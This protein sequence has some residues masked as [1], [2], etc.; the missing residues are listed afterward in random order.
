MIV[1]T[2][3][4]AAGVMGMS[5]CHDRAVAAD[6][7]FRKLAAGVLT[8]IPP[9]TSADDTEQHGDL[10]EITRGRADS[11]WK[12]NEAPSNTTLIERAKNLEFQ[13]DIWYLE[14][15]FKPPRTIDVDVP[16]LNQRMQR[17]RLWYLVYRVK[18]TGGRRTVVDKIDPS[19]RTTKKLEGPVLFL[20]HFVLEGLEALSDAEGTTS[21]RGYLIA[22]YPVQWHRSG[23][24]KIRPVNYLIA[25]RWPASRLPL[26]RNAGEWPFGRTL[27]RASTSFRS[28]C[29]A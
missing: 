28:L 27:T 19:K 18:N 4:T 13:R 16:T 22:W 17:K 9:D 29:E 26:A 1:P 21:Y 12:P 7:G 25:P 14:F 8:V 15:A 10:L 11:K 3:L 24:A 20:P 5:A 23:C 2:V 6:K